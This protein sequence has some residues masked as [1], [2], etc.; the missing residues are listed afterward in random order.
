MEES[1]RKGL[2]IQ[3][4]GLGVPVQVHSTRVTSGFELRWS[5]DPDVGDNSPAHV[6]FDHQ[7]LT[8]FLRFA[9]DPSFQ[10][11]DL[12]SFTSVEVAEGVDH[13]TKADCLA[14]GISAEHWQIVRCHLSITGSTARGPVTDKLA[15]VGTRQEYF[16]NAH[17]NEAHEH[18]KSRDMSRVTVFTTQD[19]GHLLRAAEGFKNHQRQMR[20]SLRA[21]E[22][23]MDQLQKR[24]MDTNL[25]DISS[26]HALHFLRQLQTAFVAVDFERVAEL[27]DFGLE[28][29][30]MIRMPE[31]VVEPA[32][33]KP[34]S[35]PRLH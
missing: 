22:L 16:E 25:E 1:T 30:Q 20:P 7:G 35:S 26:E 3:V 15:W 23:V 32:P 24:V 8:N 6:L 12:I 29:V 28:T 13:I 33:A 14:Y 11:A 18:A 10:E 27:Q 17:I 21:A 4:K 5:S 19:G 34:S 2:V 9:V 31:A